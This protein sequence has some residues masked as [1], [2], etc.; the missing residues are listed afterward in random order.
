M[1][2]LPYY[3]KA[4][5]WNGSSGIQGVVESKNGLEITL[6]LAGT[7]MT[8]VEDL[9]RYLE[10]DMIIQFLDVTG[11]TKREAPVK[12]ADVD[13]LGV[14]I[15]IEEDRAGIVPGDILVFS[16]SVGLENDF[17]K[18]L[19]SILDVIDDSN[20]FQEIDRS[21]VGNRK[22]RANMVDN[23]GA[24]LSRSVLSQFFKMC[25]NPK[26][27]MTS[28]KVID[29]Y[30][31]ANI[32]DKVRYNGIGQTFEDDMQFI[33]IGNTK[34]YEDEEC[35]SDKIIV[36]DFDKMGLRD[37][38]AIESLTAGMTQV[39]GSFLWE[40]VFWFKMQLVALRANK[41]GI[42]SNFSI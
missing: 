11:T 41:M 34:L 35:H 40:Q 23:G 31:E 33:Q 9:T 32:A 15:T 12:I 25:H 8:D 14:V 28:Q 21:A 30:F 1:E 7:R 37:S 22:W 4:N 10:E 2:T 42:L 18:G 29:S 13:K 38:G 20:V 26:E 39:Q 36:P 17:G 6:R 16:D 19:T 5:I 27:A 3:M 24:A